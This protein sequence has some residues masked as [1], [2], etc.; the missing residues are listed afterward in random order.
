[1]PAPATFIGPVERRAAIGAGGWRATGLPSDAARRH[2]LAHVTSDREEAVLTSETVAIAAAT[3]IGPIAAVLITRWNDRRAQRRDRMLAIY[4]TLMGTRR[5]SISQDHV[6]AINLIEVEFHEVSPVIDAWSAYITH[7]NTV[8]QRTPEQVKAWDDRRAELLALLLVKIAK[9][10]GVAKGEIE[11][12]HGGYAPQGWIDR[13]ARAT[14]VQDYVIRLS[15][16]T[17]VLPMSIQAAP[18]P[19]NPFPPAP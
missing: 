9:H 16:G 1:M 10:L 7:L 15:E 18:G 17:A 19:T 6:G 3:I 11:I 12:L 2:N 14:K 13:E 5:M 8:V 4:R